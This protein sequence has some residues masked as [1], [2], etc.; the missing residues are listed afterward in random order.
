METFDPT[1]P[2]FAPYGFTCV[3]WHPTRMQRP[4][5]HNEIE[6]NFL[7]TGWVTYLMGGRQVRIEA[8]QL[9][10]FWAVLP[11]QVIDC[12]DEPEYFVA[13]LP[14]SWFL[15]C[16]LPEAFVQS[17]LSGQMKTENDPQRAEADSQLFGEWATDLNGPHAGLREA[18]L[19]EMEARLLRM[20][21]EK[22]ASAPPKTASRIAASEGG[23]N[24][25]EQMAQLIARRYTEPLTIE[26]IAGAVNL[27]PNYA[28]GLFRK[29]FGMT[30][31]DYLT[32]H[33]VSHAERLLVTTEEKVLQ[34]AMDSG[35]GSMS[36]FSE[37]FHRAC[38]CSPREYRRQY[39]GA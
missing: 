37:A 14:L 11:H 33:R 19:M 5:R 34:V 31:I 30:L 3:R 28:M 15:Q 17:L 8:G 10:V 1:R 24:K 7:E 35:F 32:Q 13:T 25:A 16:K 22:A 2:D 27:H 39:R 21:L 4:D 18:V 20:A 6:M 29:A 26:M 23:F 12:G 36:R 9:S 38:G